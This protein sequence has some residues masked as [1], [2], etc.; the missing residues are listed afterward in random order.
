MK[1]IL[2]Q[3]VLLLAMV[4]LL[5]GEVVAQNYLQDPRYGIDED[6]RKQCA[7]SLSLYREEFNRK[8]FD[9]AKPHWQQVLTICPAASQNVYIHGAR[10]LKQW[11]NAEQNDTR[12]TELIDSLMMLYDLRI[13]H[14]NRKGILL[15]QKGMDLVN[16]DPS[17]YD[18]A[19]PIVKQ[20]VDLEED[21]SD[22][23]V[24][25]TLMALSKTMYDNDKV[26]AEEVIENYARI[27]DYI[28]VQM[29]ENA[30]NSV[31]IQVKEN[32]DAIFSSAGVANCEN[33]THLFEQRVM[34]NP[35]DKE[36]VKKTYHLLSANRCQN[37]DFFRMVAEN[38]YGKEPSA[39]LAHE[40]AKLFDDIDSY[41]VAEQYYKNA[42]ELEC[43]SIR[44][45]AYLFEYA[46]MAFNKKNRSQESRSLAL[47][48]LAQNPGLG[49]AYI[50]IGNIYANERSCFTDD[51]LKKTVYWVAVDKYIRAKQV[52]PS[53]E[54]ECNRL[55]EAYSHY[56]PAQNDI[57]FQDLQ[58]GE[59][60][61]VG[62]WINEV[63]TVRAR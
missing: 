51:F 38:L 15:G 49:H 62:C 52:D 34:N 24:L 42:I 2:K 16:L 19:Y 47:K 5:F 8:N 20:S 29:G 27:V 1:T 32:V 43:D 33:L 39:S 9:A 59:R 22:S 10:M 60:Y 61:T 40:L 30:E 35:E 3:G 17:R 25:Y 7:I 50:L 53:L 26:S 31:L 41:N 28:D 14:F 45:S 37:S 36:L 11:I 4:F 63:T 54:N 48:A 58:P 55:I 18:E 44:K 21:A 12:K 56:F 57:F 13:A 23:P 46:S 6:A